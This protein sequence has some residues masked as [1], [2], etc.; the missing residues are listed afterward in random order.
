MEIHRDEELEVRE[1]G[2]DQFFRDILDCDVRMCDDPIC[3]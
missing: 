1:T 2:L 3:V